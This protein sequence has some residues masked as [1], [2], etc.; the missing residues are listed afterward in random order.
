[1]AAGRLRRVNLTYPY[2]VRDSAKSGTGRF[3]NRDLNDRVES[4][5]MNVRGS[6]ET[7]ATIRR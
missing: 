4:S 6:P 3:G 1:M 7:E 2:G 5:T